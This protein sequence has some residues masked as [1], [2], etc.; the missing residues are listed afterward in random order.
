MKVGEIW[1]DK[2]YPDYKVKITKFGINEY[3]KS[4]GEYIFIEMVSY[5]FTS[6]SK[7]HN[8]ISIIGYDFEAP[9]NEFLERF[10]RYYESG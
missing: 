8:V 4:W 7:D 9:L 1:Q 3:E 10:R 5:I 2:K 6:G